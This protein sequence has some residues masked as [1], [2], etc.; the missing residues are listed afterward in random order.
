MNK[1]CFRNVESEKSE[2]EWEAEFLI[3]EN[4]AYSAAQCSEYNDYYETVSNKALLR[5]RNTKVSRNR[6]RKVDIKYK[7]FC[8]VCKKGYTRRSDM[9]RHRKLKHGSI[10]NSCDGTKSETD[11]TSTSLQI[12]DFSCRYCSEKFEKRIELKVHVKAKHGISRFRRRHNEITAEYFCDICEKGFTR[13]HDMKKHRKGKHPNAVSASEIAKNEKLSYLKKLK[14]MGPENRTYYRCDVC[15][16]IFKYAYDMLRHQTTHT[17]V[18]VFV[19]HICAKRF[20]SSNG[21]RRHINQ[22]HYGVKKFSCEICGKSFAANATREEH[23]NIHTN[24]R[25]FVCDICGKAFKQKASLRSHKLFH[26]NDFKFS[27]NFCDK[28]FRRAYELKT[29]TWTHTGHRPHQCH[30]CSS[31]FRLGQD[32]KRHLKVHDKLGECTCDECGATFSQQK[33]LNNHKRSHKTQSK[34]DSKVTSESVGKVPDC[35]N[36]KIFTVLAS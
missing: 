32:L 13:K 35:G 2:N 8:E 34:D 28:K 14:V 17:K 10:F 22:H 16:K 4:H 6:R 36:V 18:Y 20:P 33:Y 30:L 31:T 3:I 21:L 15:K 24:N 7:I 11:V 12:L 29:H 19:C 27:C 9:E 23:M 25:P 26:T 5:R 1:Y